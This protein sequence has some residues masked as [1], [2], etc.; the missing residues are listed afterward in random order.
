MAVRI[1]PTGSNDLFS[2]RSSNKAKGGD[3]LRHSTCNV[4]KIAVIEN[5]VS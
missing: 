1:I 5:G 2:K 4:S 3:E